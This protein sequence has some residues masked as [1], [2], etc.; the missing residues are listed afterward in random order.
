M[1]DGALERINDAA[2]DRL[3]CAA[4]EGDDL[5]EVNCELFAK[6]NA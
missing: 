3:D 6:E 2:F 1:I 4:L 5:I